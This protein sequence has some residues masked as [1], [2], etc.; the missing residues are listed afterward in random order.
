MLKFDL[1]G[2]KPSF[3]INQLQNQQTYLGLLFTILIG[4]F[5]F[6][7]SKD[8]ISNYIYSTY[9][10]ISEE[11]ATESTDLKFD[12]ENKNPVMFSYAYLDTKTF[13]INYVPHDSSISTPIINYLDFKENEVEY[14]GLY[15]TEK[16][17]MTDIE[18]LS[19]N[20][21]FTGGI[22]DDYWKEIKKNAVR[23]YCFPKNNN[24]YANSDNQNN[25]RTIMINVHSNILDQLSAYSNY[26]SKMFL[27]IMYYP[28]TYLTPGNNA[29][30][31]TKRLEWQLFFLSPET[32][33]MYNIDFQRKTTNKI[34]STYFFDNNQLDYF[35]SMD[36]NY[37]TGEV[38]TKYMNYLPGGK[39]SLILYINK[40][41]YTKIYNFKFTTL[42]DV[43]SNIGGSFELIYLMLSIVNSVLTKFSYHAFLLNSIFKFHTSNDLH[44]KTATILRNYSKYFKEHDVNEKKTYHDLSEREI[45]V[46]REVPNNENVENKRNT[47]NLMIKST[48]QTINTDYKLRIGLLEIIKGRNS[49]KI[50]SYDAFIA[51]LNDIIGK[52]TIKDNLILLSSSIDQQSLDFNAIVKSV[53]DIET[54]KD[55]VVD[56]DFANYLT[57]PSLNISKPTSSIKMLS[58][59][60]TKLNYDSINVKL[61]DNLMDKDLSKE[62]YKKIIQNIAESC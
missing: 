6:L 11:Y 23:S 12:F 15:F 8:S 61:I 3:K 4:V 36:K 46:S 19:K 16:C 26:T 43:I 39:P 59:L 1:V 25:G 7:N 30:F 22:E 32:S 10:Q 35:F 33:K 9:P 55:L 47:K 34:F 2:V 29:K 18:I 13:K 24:T 21:T 62:A 50:S 60:T 58:K 14:K 48:Q 27:L 17:N 37:L 20:D 44:E 40:T 51:R 49:Y 5:T 54:L 53:L 31:Y 41:I 28:Q 38:E 57:F 45:N 42:N 52:T 56:E